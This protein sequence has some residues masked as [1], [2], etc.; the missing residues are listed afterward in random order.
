MWPGFVPSLIFIRT[1]P[2]FVPRFLLYRLH[3]R[4]MLPT[5]VHVRRLVFQPTISERQAG[6]FQSIP[7]RIRVNGLGTRDDT[8]IY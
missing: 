6:G 5:T 3:P 1:D 2:L 4:A 7:L 8:Q